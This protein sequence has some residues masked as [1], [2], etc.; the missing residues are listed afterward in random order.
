VEAALADTKR[1]PST[2]KEDP[3]DHDLAGTPANKTADFEH[4]HSV[5]MPAE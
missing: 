2:F 3:Y 4:Q 5:R 1:S